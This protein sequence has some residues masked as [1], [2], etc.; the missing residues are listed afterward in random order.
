MSKYLG[1]ATVP[2]HHYCNGIAKWGFELVLGTQQT[3]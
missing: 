2:V 3:P 1:S